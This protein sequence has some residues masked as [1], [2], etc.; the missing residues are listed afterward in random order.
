MNADDKFVPPD[1]FRVSTPQRSGV[2]SDR[3]RSNRFS[4]RIHGQSRCYKR[5][6]KAAEMTPRRGADRAGLSLDALVIAD[7]HYRRIRIRLKRS[8]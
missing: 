5:H 1:C 3:V 7:L 4:G 8:R 2:G 6:S